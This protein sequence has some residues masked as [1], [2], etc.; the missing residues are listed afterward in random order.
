MSTPSIPTVPVGTDGLEGWT[1][2]CGACV[3]FSIAGGG[4]PVLCCKSCWSE[5]ERVYPQGAVGDAL[6]AAVAGVIDEDLLPREGVARQ[7]ELIGW[8][9]S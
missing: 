1:S 3:T 5:V 7:R 8:P 6:N 2:C 9:R 4:D